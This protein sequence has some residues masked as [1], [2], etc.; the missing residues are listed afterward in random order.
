M[1]EANLRVLISAEQIDQRIVAMGREIDAAYP[2]GPIYLI[3]I[4]KGSWIFLA[5]LARRHPP[6]LPHRIP[7]NIELRQGQNHFPAKCGSPRTSTRCL[8]A[9]T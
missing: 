6:P 8:K 4:L 7:R 2:P 9:R 5:D 1:S 3:G